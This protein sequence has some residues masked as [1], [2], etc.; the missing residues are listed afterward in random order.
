MSRRRIGFGPSRATIIQDVG[1]AERNPEKEP[2]R[3]DAL[4]E[5]RHSGAA[6]RQMQLV[7]T[8]V[9]EARGAG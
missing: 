7:A 8:H 2:Q 1:A 9:L 5:G 3:R 4:V 6:R